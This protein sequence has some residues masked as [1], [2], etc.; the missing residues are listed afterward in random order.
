M[1]DEIVIKTKHLTKYF[2]SLA[3]VNDVSINIHKNTMHAIIGPN[4][5]G[6]TT[7]FNLLSGNLKPTNGK[8][9]YHDMDLTQQPVHRMIHFGIGRSFQITNIFPNLTVYENIRLAAQA[10]EKQ[11]YNIITKV[12][13]FTNCEAR[14]QE[15]I[16]KVSLAKQAN[17]LARNLPHG[18]Q[19]KLELGMILAP[20]PE[21]LLLDE[22]T[23]GMA[24]EQVPDLIKL[25]KEIQETGQKTV[26][27][28]EHNMNVVMNTSDQ[29]TVMHLG[30]ILAE[31][32]PAEIAANE[33]V[34]TAYL[35]GLYDLDV[36]SA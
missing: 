15:V 22:P 32:K 36:Q 31:G 23:A 19:R 14:T 30:K 5:A 7:L 29:I 3:A 8:I 10:L 18:D 33:E 21:V 20:D 26:V 13:K 12:E 28:V 11:K 2:G 6:K 35:G 4:G 24:S 16:E 34:Q 27:L 25:I 1:T 9:F 17:N